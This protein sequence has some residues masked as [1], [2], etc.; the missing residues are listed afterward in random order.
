MTLNY[1]IRLSSCL[2][3]KLFKI[4]KSNFLPLLTLDFYC[5]T[6]LSDIMPRY[7]RLVNQD[8]LHTFIKFKD[9]VYKEDRAKCRYYYVVRA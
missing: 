1:L 3:H 8:V 6:T 5:S 4:L 2:R 9:L 7:G